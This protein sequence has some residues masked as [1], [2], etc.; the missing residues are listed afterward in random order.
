M[1]VNGLITAVNITANSGIFTGNGSGLTSLT[2]ANVSG[3]V[4]LATNATSANA[5]AGANVSGTVASAT[6][7]ASATIAGTVTTAAQPNITSVGTLLVHSSTD[8]ISAAG[9][10][11]GT[12]TLLSSEINR[13]TVVSTNTG[14]KLPNAQGGLMIFVTNTS[15]NALK[16]YPNTSDQINTLTVNIAFTHPAGA[17][18]QYICTNADNWYTVG[19]TYA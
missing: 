12:A 7:A 14:V 10:T 2:G 6:S 19:A 3:A 1:N 18:L 13:V 17:T 9:T 16:V 15:A 5:V 4:A 11:Q 8:S